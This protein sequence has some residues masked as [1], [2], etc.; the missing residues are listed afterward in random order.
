MFFVYIQTLSDDDDND[1]DGSIAIKK[2]SL[3]I[4][5]GCEHLHAFSIETWT[6]KS[7]SCLYAH[8][9]KP[10]ETVKSRGQHPLSP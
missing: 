8:L 1:D 7:F 9:A 6:F 5:I 3:C 10:G 2:E 4:F